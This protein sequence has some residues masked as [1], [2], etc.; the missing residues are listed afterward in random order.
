[1]KANVQ[2]LRKNRVYAR[3]Y[4]VHLVSC[5]RKAAIAFCS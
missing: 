5:M 4:K 3:E 2:L 1:M